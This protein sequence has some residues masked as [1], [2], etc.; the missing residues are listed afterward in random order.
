MATHRKR[1]SWLRIREKIGKL[2]K[3]MIYV[4]LALMLM[5]FWFVLE[6]RAHRKHEVNQAIC[7]IIKAIP[8]GNPRIDQVRRDFRCGDYIPPA[9]IP[10][11][12]KPSPSQIS[13]IPS[14]SVS[15]NGSP[16]KPSS[17]ISAHQTVI[18]S[19][20]G[21]PTRS[22]ASPI[23]TN[24]TISSIPTPTSSKTSI[25]CQTLQLPVLCK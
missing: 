6:D 17:I 21:T 15:P 24:T 2:E 23:S 9:I 19:Q 3:P 14:P 12:P 18:S 4:S 22:R 5:T 20:G 7:S 16:V 8:P 10:P 25:V 1:W 11:S 13:L